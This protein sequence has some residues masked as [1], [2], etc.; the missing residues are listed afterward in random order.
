MAFFETRNSLVT[1][2]LFEGWK[3]DTQELY[4]GTLVACIAL[5]VIVEVIHHT[6]RPKVLKRLHDEEKMDWSYEVLFPVC[7]LGG[8]VVWNR[9]HDIIPVDA[10][11]YG[12]QRWC[13][14]GN[15]VGVIFWIPVIR[16]SA[17]VKKENDIEVRFQRWRSNQF[18][19]VDDVVNSSYA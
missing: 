2:F 19:Q 1:D 10:C 7:G 12:I 18:H 6:I 11:G 13:P 16:A 14:R 3:V 9:I 17:R 4:I 15:C 8:V 5:T